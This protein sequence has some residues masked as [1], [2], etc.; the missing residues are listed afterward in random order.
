MGAD[1]KTQRE[2]CQVHMA[3]HPRTYNTCLVLDLILVSLCCLV[4]ISIAVGVAA[5]TIFG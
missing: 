2:R 1:D 3:A 5:K 4:I